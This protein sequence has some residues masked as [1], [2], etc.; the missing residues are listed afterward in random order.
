M[1][2]FT[3]VFKRL[4]VISLLYFFMHKSFF[5][6]PFKDEKLIRGD[7][8]W[9]DSSNGKL[10]LICHGLKAFRNWG[11]HPQIAKRVAH[12]GF[13]AGLID[14][15]LNGYK[16][17][18]E[19][20]SNFE[21][22]KSNSILREVEEIKTAANY[23]LTDKK[24]KEI[25]TSPE[26]ILIGHSKGGA[27]VIVAGADLSNVQKIVALAPVIDFELAMPKGVIAD[28]EREGVLW[29]KDERTEQMLPLG[30][31]L[32]N[33]IKNSPNMVKEALGKI[34][35]PILIIHGTEDE[36]VLFKGSEEAASLN[37]RIKLVAIEG[38][39]HNFNCDHP[40]IKPSKELEQVLE[41]IV[42]FLCA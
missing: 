9:Q 30:K 28:W 6:V 35:V 34:K 38:A 32:L 11:I 27:D 7:L 42:S 29:I 1:S 14:F 19:R 3:R 24:Y 17:G 10:V 12:S 33:E 41:N 4:A 39:D 16:E 40:C 26:I 31:N 2:C 21:D 25:I 22:F 5:S 23:L 20:V 18:E 13:V 8:Y 37:P 36:T 15:S